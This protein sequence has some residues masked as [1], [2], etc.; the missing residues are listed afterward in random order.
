MPRTKR[1]AI[2][3]TGIPKR[4]R[5][6]HGRSTSPPA[7]PGS[8][9]LDMPKIARCRRRFGALVHQINLPAHAP[10]LQQL[11]GL[12]GQE[13]GNVGSP[14]QAFRPDL[15]ALARGVPFP[16]GTPYVRDGAT[17]R[18]VA[19]LSARPAA[20]AA[21]HT[22]YQPPPVAWQD[23]LHKGSAH[24]NPRKRLILGQGGVRL[25]QKRGR[26]DPMVAQGA[27]RA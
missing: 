12:K 19:S 26:S 18:A 8:G 22:R 7:A 20:P 14:L 13:N 3:P 15:P 9:T 23:R 17:A 21:P 2:S 10:Q 4:E 16:E 27:A 24:P 1:L 25:P 5:R 6:S 11:P